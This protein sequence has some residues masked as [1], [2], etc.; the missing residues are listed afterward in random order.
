MEPEKEKK[1]PVKQP[2][3][4]TREDEEMFQQDRYEEQFE[5]HD[6]MTESN[7]CLFL[8]LHKKRHFT[9]KCPIS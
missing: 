2:H 8:Y 6:A 7:L 9:L 1:K 4:L 3:I 5:S